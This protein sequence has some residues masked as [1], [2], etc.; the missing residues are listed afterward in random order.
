MKM[1]GESLLSLAWPWGL[2]AGLLLGALAAAVVLLRRPAVPALTTAAALVGLILVALGAGGLTWERPAPRPIVVMVDLS[3]ST[4]TAEYRDRTALDRRIHELLGAAPYRLVFFSEENLKTDPGTGYLADVPADHTTYAPPAAAGVLLFSDCRFALP[5]QAAPTY[6]VV[7]AGLEDPDD[8]SVADLEVRGSDV[9]VT[10]NNS[11]GPR[12]LTIA[13]TAGASPAPAPIGSTVV[14]LPLQARA[15]KVSAELSPGDPWPENDLLAAVV[16]SAQE[17]QRWWVGPSSMGMDWRQMSPGQLP[18][19]PAAY[20]APEVIVLE[21]V[22]ASDLSEIQQQRLRQYVRDLG[23]GLV[24][25]GGDRSFAAGGY[26]GSTLDALSPLASSP[27]VPTTHWVLLVDA[28][29]SMAADAAGTT[30]WKLASDAAAGLLPHLPPD[31]LVSIG[32]FAENIDWWISGKPVREARASALP[33][34]DRYPHGPTNLQPALEAVA[35]SADGKMSLQALVLSDFDA[36]LS[37]PTE[38]ATLLRSKQARLHLLA[39]G[40]GTA[41]PALREVV[42]LTGG[43]VVRQLDPTQW[44]QS[45]REL[46]RAAGPGRMET[47]RAEVTF[48][49]EAAPAGRFTASPWDRVWLKE[50]ATELAEGRHGNETLPMAARWNVGEG[51]VLA[52][53]FALAPDRVEPLARLAA[54]PPHDPRFRLNWQTGPRLRVTIDALSGSQ[55]LNGLRLALE[56]TDA[57]GEGN[58]VSRPIPQSG[59]GRYELDVP[60]PRSPGVA[61]VRAEGQVIG[62]LAMAGRYAPEFD[63]LGNDHAAMQE[64]ARRTGGQVIAPNRSGPLDIRWP[65]LSLALTSYL[66]AAG[67]ALIA[68]SLGWWKFH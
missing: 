17:P 26:I 33:P 2:W 23:G 41:L 64:L 18:D 63:A 34:A 58:L 12:R 43:T 35:N 15:T 21:N 60:A 7:D 44:A 54:R 57:F 48:T 50:S 37:K 59:P 40:E 30:R 42:R 13:G 11:G 49:G 9:S 61:R 5:E 53:A 36:Q 1:I 29:G 66:A 8:A 19:D 67:A 24:I 39:I 25:L 68:L 27:P 52:V 31:D 65:T 16:P 20:L 38:L 56:L 46:A 62:R 4:R 28:S 32:T 22:A 45:A 14:T 10:V 3:P 55:Y 6:V 47:D 51:Q